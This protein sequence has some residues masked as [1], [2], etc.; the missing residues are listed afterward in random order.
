MQGLSRR[1]FM[2]ATAL[3]P[4][5]V[6]VPAAERW[7]R[8]WDYVLAPEG[9]AI[10]RLDLGRLLSLLPEEA[11]LRGG[12]QPPARLLGPEGLERA[13]LSVHRLHGGRDVGEV[14]PLIRDARG[15]PYLPGSS[16]KGAVRSALLWART[17]GRE[18]GPE[19][20]HRDREGR[21]VPRAAGQRI[22]EEFLRPS[23]R[24]Q[25]STTGANY[26]LLRIV[27]LSDALPLRVET[28]VARVVWV[29]RTRPQARDLTWAEFFP[30]GARLVFWL[31]TDRRLAEEE[32]PRPPRL[33]APPLQGGLGWPRE[34][35]DLASP[36]HLARLCR[37][38][39]GQVLREQL[40]LAQELQGPI[41]RH[42]LDVLEELSR[43]LKGL[44]AEA[45][46]LPVGWGT[47]L[48][49]KTVAGRLT[50]PAL[51][52]AR[53]RKP[54]GLRLAV[55]NGRETPLGWL[56]VRPYRR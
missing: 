11:L 55:M 49:G 8:E 47:G 4:V 51:R 41:R 21:I 12:G 54:I 5:H 43:R 34:V 31:E 10:Y 29:G 45:F 42:V 15:R 38:W 36:D 6:G 3:T 40:R 20:L 13:R 50:P 37:E 39:S 16:L 26:D 48:F 30:P 33:G 7:V 22:E 25:R 18:L 44:E 56:E 32:G 46:L 17:A 9:D 23:Q 1:V 53:V 27:R 2:Q 52:Q 19:H 14:M 24:R 28:V 35:A